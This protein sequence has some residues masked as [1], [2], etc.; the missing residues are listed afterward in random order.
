[1][2][3]LS[4]AQIRA[5]DAYTIAHEPIASIDLMERASQQLHSWIIDHYPE[6][7]FQVICGPGNNGGD[8]LALSRMLLDSNINVSCYIFSS[9]S[10]SEDFL[11]NLDKL[12]T[13]TQ[14][15]EITQ[16]DDLILKENTLMIDA[17]FGSG[18]TRSIEGTYAKIIK[19]VNE[20]QI[21]IL[22][23]DV[24]SGVF[25]DENNIN[26][27]IIKATHTLTFEAP[28]LAMMMPDYSQYIGKFHVLPIGL[29]KKYLEETTTTHYFTEFGDIQSLIKSRNKFAHKGNFGHAMLIAGAKGTMGAAQL[30][31][32]A[33]LRSGV[34][35]LTCHIPE[36]GYD[37]MQ[38][39][40]P[41]AMCSTDPHQTKIT[42]VEISNKINAIGIGPGIGT[43]QETVIALTKL[44]KGIEYPIVLDADALN[45]L[46][47]NEELW[48]YIPEHS[49][50]TPHVGEFDRLFPGAQD[51]FERLK[52]AQEAAS[53]YNIIVILK[54]A[55]TAVCC[56]DST[57]SFNSTGNPGM[58]T[59]GS[60]DVLTGILTSLLAQG[61]KAQ[62]AAKI[63]VYAHGYAG[64][65][66]C[67]SVG[68]EGLIASD[69]I[70]CIPAFYKAI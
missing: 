31:T 25:C 49:I 15:T 66:A 70:R 44:I 50:I 38:L 18:L 63:G 62:D 32:M 23:V 69:I 34:G 61:Y 1:M 11:I 56:P 45:I 6:K 5:W 54:G 2:K 40:C 41:E 28:K 48:E 58:A 7:E 9:N 43:A 17:I 24:P 30:A 68:H 51:S 60:G 29:H 42:S 14:V 53:K 57:I 21:P 52:I 46:S 26:E 55:H 64:D 65:L 47:K 36:C 13:R 19:K 20:S 67:Q 10:Y 22:S 37:I 4:A 27:T 39:A 35:L 59:G 33:C 8:G 12:R 3:I 16:A